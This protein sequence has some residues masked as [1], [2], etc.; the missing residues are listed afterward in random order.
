MSK[1][2]FVLSG[3]GV[4]GCF[5]VGVLKQLHSQG[6]R[7]DVVYGTSVGAL[8][9]TAFSYV[10]VQELEKIWLDLR[11]RSDIVRF[12]LGTVLF[13]SKG[14]YSMTPLRK[15]V[16][17]IV[18]GHQPKFSLP[19]VCTLNILSGNIAYI[20]PYTAHEHN[21]TFSD[22]VIASS[23]IPL[24]IEPVKDYW[25]DGGVREISPLREAIRD[26]CNEIYVI[27]TEPYQRNLKTIKK[28]GSWLSY[29]LRTL[30]LL[31]HEVFLNDLQTCLFYNTRENKRHIDL[32]IFA[33]N[34]VYLTTLEFDPVKIRRSIL[35][36][37]TAKEIANPQ[38][39]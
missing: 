33:P 2:G 29:G 7:P 26:G 35:Q 18:M 10:G 20:N 25:V 4:K 36:G 15:L 22:A 31:L 30:T 39:I 6:I 37:E 8:N 13:A 1:C 27:L 17:G 28:L 19:V 9:A 38:E 24:Y 3:G 14:I 16:D 5:Q 34:E 12:Q 21:M 11:R 32:H 23:S